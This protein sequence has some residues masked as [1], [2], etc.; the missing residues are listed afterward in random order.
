M[1][2]QI[3][4]PNKYPRGSSQ[5]KKTLVKYGASI[6]ANATIV[7]GHTI[8]RWALIA[9]GAV[10]TKMFRLCVNGRRSC[11]ADRMGL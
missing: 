8:G 5:Y 11:Q 1:V 7:C 4:T 10:V 3:L 9:A 2:L 6:G